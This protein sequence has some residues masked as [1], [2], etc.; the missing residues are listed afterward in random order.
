MRSLRREG[1]RNGLLCFGPT[2]KTEEMLKCGLYIGVGEGVVVYDH[3]AGSEDQVVRHPFVCDK[4][5]TFDLR[6]DADL[7]AKVV[8]VT[9]DGEVTFE[10]PIAKDWAAVRYVGYNVNSTE[11]AFSAITVEGY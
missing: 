6:A 2:A 4:A 3:F 7:K 5:K 10:A 9:I 11:T 1:T 8:R